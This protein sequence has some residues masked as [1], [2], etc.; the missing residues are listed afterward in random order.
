MLEDLISYYRQ[1]NLKLH[2]N[3]REIS[4]NVIAK[5]QDRGILV[6]KFVLSS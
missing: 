2:Q 3:V 5:V 4:Y 6:R 1:Q